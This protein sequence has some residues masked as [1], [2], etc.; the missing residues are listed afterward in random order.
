MRHLYRIGPEQFLENYSGL[1]A[2]YRDGGRWN[3]SGHPVL[4]FALSPA[5]ALLEMANYLP[6]PRLVPPAY[7][8]GVY[9]LADTSSVARLPE[10][11]WPADWAQYPYPL[12]TQLIGDRWL[13]A[14]HELGLILPSAAVP[15]GME[16]IMLVNPQHS[17]S[18]SIR[19]I[20]QISDLYNA[21][22]FSGIGSGKRSAGALGG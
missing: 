22:A 9:E 1:G 4:Y 5:T 10:S 21:R 13:M 18:Q 19:L 15:G 20:R 8:L 11:E 3:S 17:A 2:S 7:R 6:S 16:S 12:S 14:G